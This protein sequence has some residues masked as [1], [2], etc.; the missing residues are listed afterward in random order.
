MRRRGEG[1][2]EDRSIW[3]HLHPNF[4]FFSTLPPFFMSR[5]AD[6]SEGDQILAETSAS[7]V[8]VENERRADQ[9]EGQASKRV[10][11]GEAGASCCT[12]FLSRDTSRSPGGAHPRSRGLCI[13]KLTPDIL[14]SSG[15][16]EGVMMSLMLLAVAAGR[17]DLG[18][19]LLF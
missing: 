5:H 6:L 17:R 1:R 19:G 12:G 18:K 16:K 4:F 7:G 14:L 13:V 9:Q 11:P 10:T 3:H 15:E 2:T 8:P